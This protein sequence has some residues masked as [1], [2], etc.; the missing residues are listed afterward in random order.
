MQLAVV[1]AA[2]S[3]SRNSSEL[4]QKFEFAPLT[5]ISLLQT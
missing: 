5:E 1:V 4:Q 2:I 3:N